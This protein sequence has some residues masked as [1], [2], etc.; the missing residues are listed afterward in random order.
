MLLQYGYTL[1]LLR[2]PTYLQSSIHASPV[3]VQITSIRVLHVSKV[4]STLF[5][6][7]Y[8]LQLLSRPIYFHG[9]EMCSMRIY[10]TVSVLPRYGYTL[11]LL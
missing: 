1:Q 10:I 6:C 11:Q 8:T 4:V 5:Q 3:W 7:G 9:S 2:R